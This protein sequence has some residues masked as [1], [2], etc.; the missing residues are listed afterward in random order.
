LFLFASRYDD[1]KD[2]FQEY[3]HRELLEAPTL[4][5]GVFFHVS[6]GEKCQKWKIDF[7]TL[8]IEKFYEG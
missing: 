8:K 4:P 7:K 1:A 5:P 3:G 6:P 2:L